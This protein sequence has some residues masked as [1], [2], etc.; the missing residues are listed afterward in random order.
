MYK[1]TSF[2]NEEDML[3]HASY[4]YNLF[5]IR[6][7]DHCRHCSYYLLEEKSLHADHQVHYYVGA[8]Q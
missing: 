6:K 2:S 5:I 8:Y 3:V 4:N 1:H 7:A